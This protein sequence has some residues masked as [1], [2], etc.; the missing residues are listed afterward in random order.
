M[1][2]H[3]CEICGSKTNRLSNLRAHLAKQKKCKPPPVPEPQIPIPV[4]VN[5]NQCIK[6]EKILSTAYCLKQHLLIC[7]GCHIL[8]C[9]KCLKR[10]NHRATKHH[11]VNNDNCEPA[12]IP[13][14]IHEEL[15]RLRKENEILKRSTPHTGILGN[16]VGDAPSEEYLKLKDADN[17]MIKIENDMLKRD[18]ENRRLKKI[19]EALKKELETLS[20]KTKPKR[21]LVNQ[22]TRNKIAASQKWCCRLCEVILPGVFNIDHTIPLRYGGGDIRENVSALCIQCHAEKTQTDF[23]LYDVPGK[24]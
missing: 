17:N 10:F 11:H 16:V 8:Q 23:Q 12:I 19:N 7:K 9:P 15:E 21:G 18:I 24:V 1:S 3:T 13:E 4:V 6:C 20:N 2:I 22:V 5:P 14:T